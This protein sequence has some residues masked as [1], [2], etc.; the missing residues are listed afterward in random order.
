MWIYDY[1]LKNGGRK[2]SYTDE[3]GF[4]RE[5]AAFYDENKEQIKDSFC[6]HFSCTIAEF[7]NGKSIDEGI[8]ICKDL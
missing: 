3:P 4:P 5:V 8:V 6:Y 2:Q 1:C 7:T